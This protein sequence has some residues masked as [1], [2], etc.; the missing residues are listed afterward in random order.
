M[1]KR[2]YEFAIET[3]DPAKVIKGL[4]ELG[5]LPQLRS[6]TEQIVEL[7]KGLVRPVVIVES[8]VVIGLLLLAGQVVPLELWGIVGVIGGEYGIERAVKRWKQS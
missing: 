2:A 6:T 1:M 8:M 4:T 5:Y 7:F 3:D